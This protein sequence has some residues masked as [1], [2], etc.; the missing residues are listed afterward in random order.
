MVSL[1]QAF[2][3]KFRE[4]AGQFVDQQYRGAKPPIDQVPP[5]MW[6]FSVAEKLSDP[7]HHQA[8]RALLLGM[9]AIWRWHD[10]SGFH[11]HYKG[12]AELAER[13]RA[14]GGD[15]FAALRAAR[16][17]LG[18]RGRDQLMTEI[19]WGFFL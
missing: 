1:P 17:E 12:I 4:A 15:R 5:M 14:R 19:L 7:R 13:N 11:D 16:G 9:E 18:Q 10:D 2:L 8:A 3:I 6:V